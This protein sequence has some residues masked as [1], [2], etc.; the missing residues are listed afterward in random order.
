L[1]FPHFTH[2]PKLHRTENCVFI[3]T[4]LRDAYT[5]ELPHSTI[6]SL[7]L[8]TEPRRT[9][10]LTASHFLKLYYTQHL[11]VGA[12][13]VF[14]FQTCLISKELNPMVGALQH[15]KLRTKEMYFTHC[16]S[17]VCYRQTKLECVIQVIRCNRTRG[18]NSDMRLTQLPFKRP[19]QYRQHLGQ[20][21]KC[22]RF[23]SHCQNL[24]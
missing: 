4:T 1:Y 21:F 24:M 16:P 18:D 5:L 14:H 7:Q 20:N 12:D 15:K 8:K 22:L 17:C 3:V 19:S 9:T 6:K 23:E 10:C 13:N 2:K 11:T